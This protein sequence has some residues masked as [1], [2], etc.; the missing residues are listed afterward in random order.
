MEAVSELGTKWKRVKTHLQTTRLVKDLKRRYD[1]LINVVVAKEENDDDTV[2]ADEEHVVV[3]KKT[4]NKKLSVEAPMT[5]S[6]TAAVKARKV[7]RVKQSQSF[8]AKDTQHV[9][10][11]SF[12]PVDVSRVVRQ[13]DRQQSFP[14]KLKGKTLKMP[15]T[16]AA[17]AGSG[18]VSKKKREL[19]NSTTSSDELSLPP[20]T[21]SIRKGRVAELIG[22]HHTGLSNAKPSQ[23]LTTVD[24]E[25]S[26][27]PP[28]PRRSTRRSSVSSD[29]LDPHTASLVSPAT[30]SPAKAVVGKRKRNTNNSASSV[31]FNFT[32]PS[33]SIADS[34]DEPMFTPID[35]PI[36]T[37]PSIAASTDARATK[38]K[39][40]RLQ[41]EDND[42]EEDA[43]S[44]PT[45]KLFASS[46]ALMA[47]TGSSSNTSN[48]PKS[49]KK[50][51]S[52]R[53]KNQPVGSP[54]TDVA[55]DFHEDEENTDDLV[56]RRVAEE[57]F[58][59]DQVDADG[60]DWPM[61]NETFAIRVVKR[62]ARAM[63]LIH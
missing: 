40:V 63:F 17:L 24:E 16:P 58:G 57:D 29:T 34:C 15:S 5:P 19:L 2:V 8:L 44:E 56:D 4:N 41:S 27:T 12:D 54:W 3:V 37:T 26:G 51:P 45:P 59:V 61:D 30:P 20:F 47:W 49:T 39:R 11:A 53:A 43:F 60:L 23:S 31:V 35:Y 21:P 22:H 62:I 33:R 14:T 6:L 55:D 52:T 42:D 48:Q 9:E 10:E 32:T 18:L 28:S 13:I 38:R 1:T 36:A 7:T 25:H 46:S 50:I